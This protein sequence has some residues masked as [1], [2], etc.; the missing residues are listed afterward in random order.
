V[1]DSIKSQIFARVEELPTL[2]TVLPK[3]MSKIEDDNSSVEEVTALIKQDQALTSKVLK[4]ANSAYYG[5]PGTIHGL[6]HAVALLGFNMVKSLTL[7]IGVMRALPDESDFK[8]FSQQGLW[9]HS[10]AVATTLQLLGE[11]LELPETENLFTIGLLHDIGIVV[12]V[13]YFT[14]EF[15]QVLQLIHGEGYDQLEA[16]RKVFGCDHGEISRIVLER[17]HFPESIVMPIAL[18]HRKLLPEDMHRTTTA[19]LRIAN[20]LPTSIKLGETGLNYELEI[21][22][23]DVSALGLNKKMLERVTANLEAARADILAFTATLHQ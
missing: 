22:E 15:A 1:K 18:H 21:L 14:D 7:S 20:T 11:Q 6:R 12:Q 3:I 8:N 23:D 5:F 9:E 17:W 19:L 16:E 2:P 4:V 10:L 13:H